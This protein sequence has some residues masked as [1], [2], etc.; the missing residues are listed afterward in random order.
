MSKRAIEELKAV[1]AKKVEIE[2][3]VGESHVF[4]LPPD[5]G[6]TDLGPKWQS[7]LKGLGFLSQC[8]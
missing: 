4:D 7:V 6:A 8:V 1:G 3:V 2:R 5:V